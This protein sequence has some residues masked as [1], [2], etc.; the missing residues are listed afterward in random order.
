ML[1][2]F[3]SK[4]QQFSRLCLDSVDTSAYL[5]LGK[6]SP[7]RLYHKLM[8]LLSQGSV[9]GSTQCTCL[10]LVMQIFFKFLKLIYLLFLAA[11]GLHGCAWAFSSCGEWELIFVVV[12]K[13]LIMGLLL[14]Q[15]MV[16]RMCEFQQLW[17]E[18]SR[19]QDQ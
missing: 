12:H 6:A 13:L 2:F 5:E 7:V 16:C 9:F 15:T 3:K 17:C 19:V 1:A 18:G 4:N 14:L 10:S 11:L 8:C